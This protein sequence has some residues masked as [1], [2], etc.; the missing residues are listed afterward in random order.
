[1]KRQWLNTLFI[2][3][4]SLLMWFGIFS[5]YNHIRPKN[6]LTDKEWQTYLIKENGLK[7]Y[8]KIQREITVKIIQGN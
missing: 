8:Y 2:Y 6:Y 5:L 4:V 3:G 1:M 7:A